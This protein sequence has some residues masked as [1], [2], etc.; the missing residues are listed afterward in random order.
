VNTRRDISLICTAGTRG[1]NREG[2]KTVALS[3][4]PKFRK[5]MMQED[6]ANNRSNYS[7]FM[8]TEGPG[9]CPLSELS[10]S[11]K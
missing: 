8:V 11:R 3:R 9:A 7:L 10:L 6:E 2:G 4:D 1:K 5:V